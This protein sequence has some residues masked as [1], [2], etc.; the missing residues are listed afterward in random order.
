MEPE[1]DGKP[2]AA[3]ASPSFSAD[4]TRVFDAEAIASG[5]AFIRAAKTLWRAFLFWDSATGS[6]EVSWPLMVDSK[7]DA[8]ASSMRFLREGMV[9][10]K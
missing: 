4:S 9:L 3:K 8:S 7:A 5:V 1:V 6:V 10:R 2:P